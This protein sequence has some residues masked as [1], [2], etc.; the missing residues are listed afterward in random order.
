MKIMYPTMMP[1][2]S[3]TR[4]QAAAG[5]F[6]FIAP[7]LGAFAACLSYALD[8]HVGAPGFPQAA[9]RGLG[10]A[11]S[12]RADLVAAHLDHRG[13]LGRAGDAALHEA[14]GGAVLHR[15]VAR[16]ADQV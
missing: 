6:L 3:A 9:H 2:T 15:D 4:I 8:A 16:R 5:I 10:E 7:S 14:G 1:S 11:R 13:A 12:P